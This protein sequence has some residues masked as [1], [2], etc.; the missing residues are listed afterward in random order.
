MKNIKKNTVIPLDMPA[1]IIVADHL[2]KD[3]LAMIFGDSPKSSLVIAGYSLIDHL[4]MELR[5]LNFKHC[6]V[7]V[8][9]NAKE[10]QVDFGKTSRWGMDFAVMESPVNKQGLLQEYKAFSEPNGLLVIE[11]DRL[12]SHCVKSFL[13]QAYRSDY[14]L[15]EGVSGDT[16]IGV[17]LLKHTNADLIIN[18]MPIELPEVMINSLSSS[19]DFHRANFDV[20][21]GLYTGLEPSVQR[22]TQL[23]RR[24]HW[25][26]QVHKT[27]E[28]ADEQIM[29][30]RRC[31]VGSRATLSSVILNHD[32]YVER[33]S[34]LKNTVIMPNTVVPNQRLIKN[35]I[36][37]EGT[38]FEI[39]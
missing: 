34:R 10:R 38:V 31:Y 27:S 7:L 37:H 39:N 8:K 23:G 4:L 16:K 30:D 15:L 11:I 13:D 25:T 21:A 36:V 22:N 2:L 12:R 18:A 28:V 29:I 26:S 6:T 9:G 1:V 3:E 19:R 35:A 5:D 17:T 24:Q 32:V 33:N 14:S 20:V